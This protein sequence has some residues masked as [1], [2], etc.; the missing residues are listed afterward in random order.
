MEGK[1]EKLLSCCFF[2]NWVSD[3][4]KQSVPGRIV[5]LSFFELK[6]H[7]AAFIV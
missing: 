1:A 4:V 6:G 2:K 5:L 3:N 7:S